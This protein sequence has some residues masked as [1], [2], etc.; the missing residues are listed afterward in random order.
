[1]TK[2]YIYLDTE[3]TGVTVGTHGLVQVGAQIV[4]GGEIV[5]EIN[6]NMHPLPDNVINEGALKVIGKTIEEIDAYP[7]PKTQWSTF[8]TQLSK[9]V[10]RYNNTDK[11][12][13]YGY[14]ARFDADFVRR[15]FQDSGDKYFGSYFWYPIMD[16]AV[17]AAE[18]LG[19]RREGMMGFKLGDVAKEFGVEVDKALQ[20]DA[21]YD[22][23]LTRKIHEKI[24]SMV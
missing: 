4:I 20:H 19:V 7:N 5:H 18:Y 21:L 22:V 14:N 11:L 13:F 23:I 15:W 1:M 8:T 9:F 6:L 3:T 24:V 16:V 2:K 10:D 17:L 12:W